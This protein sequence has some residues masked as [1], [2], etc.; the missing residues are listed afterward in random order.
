MNK[1][2]KCKWN[3]ATQSYVAC[4]E[5]VKRAGK[6][7]VGAVMLTSALAL[8]STN[9]LADAVLTSSDAVQVNGSTDRKYAST[10][11]PNVFNITSQGT[12]YT[13]PDTRQI[14]PIFI[15]MPG[16]KTFN[17]LGDFVTSGSSFGGFG[18]QGGSYGTVN[19][20]NNF[21]YTSGNSPAGNA[22]ILLEVQYGNTW[23][24]KGDTTLTATYN[25]SGGNSNGDAGLYG[26]IA[27]S[28][29]NAG[30]DPVNNGKYARAIFNNLTVDLSDTQTRNATNPVLVNGLRAIQG[31]HDERTPG[32]GSAGYIEIQN[33]LNIAIKA[34][35]GIGIYVSG[36][37]WNQGTADEAGPDG[38]LTPK[39]VLNNSNITLSKADKAGSA[40]GLLGVG[41]DIWD[42]HAIKLGKVRNT[43]EGAGIL[44]SKGALVIDT[45]AV[46]G[47]GIKMLRNSTLKADFDDSSTRIN[48]AGYALQIGGDDDANIEK[49][50]GIPMGFEHSQAGSHSV[51]ASFKNA[52][53]TTLGTSRERSVTGSTA[54]KD[55]IFV[56]QG[57]RNTQLNFS[58]DQTN[59]T[60]HGDGY[61]LNVSGNYNAPS[62]KIYTNTYNG[63]DEVTG[64]D[65]LEASSVTFNAKD[66]GSMTGLVTK[67]TVKENE[68]QQKVADKNATLDLN[69]SDQFTWNLAT[70]G[71]ETTALFDTT[72]LNNEAVING[73]AGDF[74][75]EGNVVSNGG[76]ITLANTETD[77]L[78]ATTQTLTIKG[79][80]T[81]SG[82]AKVK[83]NTGWNAP[84]DI[85]GADSKSDVLHITGDATGTTSV[86]A[87]GKNDAEGTISGSIARI[88][89]SALNTVPVVKVDGTNTADNFIGTAQ[90]TGAGEAQLTSRT[91]A[92][93][94]REFY[95]TLAAGTN[96]PTPVTPTGPDIVNETV[97][98]YVVSPRVNL[99]MGYTTLATLHER[100]GENQTLSWDNCGNCGKEATDQ[101]WGRIYGKSLEL[102]GKNRFG[103]DMKM[104]GFQ[105]GHDFSI[106]R[107]DE[108]GHRLTGVYFA[109]NNSNNKFTDEYRA[110][111]GVVSSDK[112]TGKS[113]A[114]AW[115][116]G[117]THTRYAQNGSYL[118]LVGQVSFLN[119][120]YNARNGVSA[121][122]KGM[123]LALS[124]E[125][126]RPYALREHK[127][128]EGVWFI[129]PQAQLSYQLLKLKD[130]QDDNTQ[131][132]GVVANHTVNGG[133]YHGL[134]ARLGVR[135][136]YNTQAAEDNY[137]T[138]TFYV[139]A[140][141]LQ[142][143]TND[144]AVSI[145][146]NGGTDSLK[147]RYAKT[148]AELGLGGQLP[149]GKQTYVYADARYE[150]N[151]GGATRQ[152]FRGTIG[153]KYTWK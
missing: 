78:P 10:S 22:P 65:A 146:K 75:L 68:N 148:W 76:I 7:T 95:W 4:S 74:T 125:V 96:P 110:E 132:N 145:S 16:G 48:T 83:L 60:A 45:T 80:Y 5:L 73:S 39:V 140:N 100:R 50:W 40:T 118:D 131:S 24:F 71:A 2:F 151:L 72:T 38:T 129:E 43:G 26:V 31:A 62:T 85:N 14:A 113:K 46:E 86:I 6:Q 19:F 94:G 90:T 93:G 135:L 34:D 35:R 84:G 134:R 152:G 59:L 92:T 42:S 88:V 27:G 61:I 122:Q 52:V 99:E 119:N 126:G 82:N 67:N 32:K 109:Y 69:L 117:A 89:S 29:V 128:S 150:R 139:I 79:N 54:R 120:K 141:L 112:S 47:G 123:A 137:R 143:L 53:F 33:D 44:E 115:S 55:L 136:A 36:N 111:N 66:A 20:E 21:S 103:V 153:V 57:Q 124:A 25:Y 107:T 28:S 51:S 17:F 108:G 8:F 133:T 87:V 3:M 9:A 77:D 37:R 138:N 147:E 13:I 130:F 58:G 105:I 91:T 15:R 41:G 23:T 11:D 116:L 70:K 101:T 98:G 114:N 149:L 63:T 18:M 1:I 81:A 12:P 49:K 127:V 104:S 106:K 56:D 102:D 144:K 142:D 30:N 97:P 64:P 121:S